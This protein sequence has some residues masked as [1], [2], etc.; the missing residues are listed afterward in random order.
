M[1]LSTNLSP[2]VGYRM[3]GI[4]FSKN[5]ALFR[6]FLR[7]SQCQIYGSIGF[8]NIDCLIVIPRTKMLI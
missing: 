5:V 4:Y 6:R 8:V 7:K 3:L 1:D 2:L